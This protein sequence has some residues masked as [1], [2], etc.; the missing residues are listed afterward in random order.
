MFGQEPGFFDAESTASGLHISGFSNR[1][2]ARKAADQLVCRFLY[3]CFYTGES[4]SAVKPANFRW[5]NRLV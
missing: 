3:G 5:G 1:L 2:Q 4:E